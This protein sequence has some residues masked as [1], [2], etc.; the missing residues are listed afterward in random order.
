[1]NE[2]GLEVTATKCGDMTSEWQQR[3]RTTAEDREWRVDAGG[4][5]PD[6]LGRSTPSVTATLLKRVTVSRSSEEVTLAGCNYGM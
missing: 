1:M 3:A 5:F 6:R 2:D 4:H